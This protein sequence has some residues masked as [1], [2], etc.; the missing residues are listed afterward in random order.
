MREPE[1][2]DSLGARSLLLALSRPPFLLVRALPVTPQRLAAE[3]ELWRLRERVASLRELEV[4]PSKKAAYL[5]QLTTA[6]ITENQFITTR[7]SLLVDEVRV[8][9][10]A[11]LRHRRHTNRVPPRFVRRFQ[12]L[13]VSGSPSHGSDG[14]PD[15]H[16]RGSIVTEGDIAL[17]YVVFDHAVGAKRALFLH[18]DEGRGCGPIRCSFGR[19]C[20]PAPFLFH[21]RHR[22]RVAPAPAP[23]ATLWP[24]VNRRHRLTCGGAALRYVRCSLRHVHVRSLGSD[25]LFA[26]L[27]FVLSL[28]CSAIAFKQVVRWILFLLPLA[29]TGAAVWVAK[30]SA[31]PSVDLE[32]MEHRDESVACAESLRPAG[33]CDEWD[34]AA[35][36]ALVVPVVVAVGNTLLARLIGPWV[37]GSWDLPLRRSD[38]TTTYWRTVLVL[39][40]LNTL[41]VP[42]SLSIDFLGGAVP[43]RAELKEF[44]FNNFGTVEL[45]ARGAHTS[46]NRAW[47]R[48]VGT[49]MVLGALYT[50]V[51][52][53]LDLW[54]AHEWAWRGLRLLLVGVAFLVQSILRGIG[55][56]FFNGVVFCLPE[57]AAPILRLGGFVRVWRERL[58]RMIAV[59]FRTSESPDASLRREFSAFRFD[60]FPSVA[61]AVRT[62]LALFY[63]FVLTLV[64]VPLFP[65]FGWVSFGFALAVFWTDKAA[66]VAAVQMHKRTLAQRVE[67]VKPR[68]TFV[69]FPSREVVSRLQSFEFEPVLRAARRGGHWLVLIHLAVSTLV[70]VMPGLFPSTPTVFDL[71]GRE[72]SDALELDAHA[73]LDPWIG[74]SGTSTVLL[75]LQQHLLPLVLVAVLFLLG[76]LLGGA[77]TCL[78]DCCSRRRALLDADGF[79]EQLF[80]RIPTVELVSKELTRQHLRFSVAECFG[81]VR[82]EPSYDVLE[83]PGYRCVLSLALSSRLVPLDPRRH[84]PRSLPPSWRRTRRSML[85]AEEMAA[86]PTGLKEGLS[87]ELGADSRGAEARQ[88]EQQAQIVRAQ[89]DD[90]HF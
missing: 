43:P 3:S 13:E 24:N 11:M 12:E 47:V 58:A 50:L 57:F 35:L 71:V 2:D 6:E 23:A 70:L 69:R 90:V 15:V 52:A 4:N 77:R 62:S 81:L 66:V 28:L 82:G 75:F 5:A 86:R 65:W 16:R 63:A 88:R 41:A 40:F 39:Q 55:S 78:R 8:A 53:T 80:A 76:T 42:L 30:K 29:G 32:A 21:M 56:L 74:S 72:A 25:D 83:H 85:L 46:F 48:G 89:F 73:V 49:D 64:L 10:E 68:D 44:W 84:L 59:A 36:M 14:G 19:C 61:R 79:G 87:F 33:V 34:G 54:S 60:E 37:A 9:E 20:L 18:G 26:I 38:A 31:R 17:A 51:L 27:F 22:L 67:G 7:L 1:T 45:L